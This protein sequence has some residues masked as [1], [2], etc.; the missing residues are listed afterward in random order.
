MPHSEEFEQ[1]TPPLRPGRIRL[2]QQLLSDDR[3]WRQDFPAASADAM[4]AEVNGAGMAGKLA[5]ARLVDEHG[6]VLASYD[7]DQDEDISSAK[8]VLARL[9]E[10]ADLFRSDPDTTH[11]AEFVEGVQRDI[12]AW[13]A[14]PYDSVLE[15]RMVASMSQFNQLT[16]Q[17]RQSVNAQ[18]N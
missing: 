4:E 17:A 12:E 8:A 1:D 10:V 5:W 7:S 2:W 11:G 16:A 18:Q 14:A 15:R 6:T 9:P 3:L 13:L